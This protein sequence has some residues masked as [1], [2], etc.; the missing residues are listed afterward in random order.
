MDGQIGRCMDWQT[1]TDMV[2]LLDSRSID[3]W[4]MEGEVG[5]MDGWMDR[6]TDRWM[7]GSIDGSMEG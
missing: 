6:Q 1:D 5:V 3:Q 7:D 4:I 2:R